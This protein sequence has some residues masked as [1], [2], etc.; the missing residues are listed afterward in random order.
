MAKDQKST[1]FQ[2][3]V[4]ITITTVVML[5]GLVIREKK[6]YKCGSGD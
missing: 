1:E 4:S 2:R 6:I 5:T 3:F